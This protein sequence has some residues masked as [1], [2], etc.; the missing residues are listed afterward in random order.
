VAAGSLRLQ[1]NLLGCLA[2]AAYAVLTVL[3]Y[4]QAPALWRAEDAPRIIA[5][6][7]D[8]AVRFPCLA[9][10]RSFATSVDVIISWWIP[11]LFASAAV[12]GLVLLLMRRA[13]PPDASAL[14]LI[15]RWSLAHAFACSLAFPV[16]TQDMWLSAVWGRM[17]GSGVNPYY[18]PFAPEAL[19]GLPLDHFPMV[20][21]YGPLWGMLS[22]VVMALAGGSVLAMGILFKAVLAVAWLGSLALVAR[23]TEA[24]PMRDRCLAVGMFGWMPASVSQTLAEGHNDIAMV[25]FALL[26]LLLLLRGWQTAPV[27]LA[28]SV[29]CKYATAPL[30]LVDALFALRRERAGW[31]SFLL[32]QVAPVLVG[33]AMVAPFYRSPEFF[34]GL[35]VV[36]EWYFLRPSDGVLAIEH[37]TGIPLGPLRVAVELFFPLIA[38]YWLAVSFWSP[39]EICLKKAAA[40]TMAA[41]IFSGASHLWPWYIIWVLAF[42]AIVPGW[43]LSRF[44]LGVSMVMPFTL[45]AWWIEPV[46]PHV[47]LAAL[48]MYASAGV[49]TVLTRGRHG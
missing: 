49:W 20:M 13:A 21:T 24:R 19:A 25:A 26:W 27:A 29:M 43:W 5:F 16:F 18:V 4:V 9:L 39:T 3:S 6:F 7:D 42:A 10:Y 31:R 37:L 8:L 11:L 44:M 14:Q 17:I 1:I 22:A 15:F 12:L 47:E 38:A 30:F 34:D 33:L 35:R 28:A 45:A 40:A 48:I 41:I 23:I 32:R 36:G 46:E 2:F